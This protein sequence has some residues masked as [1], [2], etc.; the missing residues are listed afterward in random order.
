MF[1]KREIV[2]LALGIVVLVAF[3]LM[4]D[5]RAKLWIVQGY[6]ISGAILLGMEGRE[7]F[8]KSREEGNNRANIMLVARLVPVVF[9]VLSAILLSFRYHV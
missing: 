1:S 3:A 6:M 7:E 5:S 2:F 4:P 8:T 9:L